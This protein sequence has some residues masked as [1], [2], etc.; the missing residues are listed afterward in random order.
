M[1]SYIAVGVNKLDK[2]WHG[3]FGISPYFIIYNRNG[4]LIE[5]RINPHG[6]GENHKHDHNNDQPLLIKDILHD[7]TTFIG[8]KM[9]EGS[10]LKLA[11]K[12]GVETIIS[13]LTEPQEVIEI[14]LKKNKMEK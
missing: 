7:C 13:K 9:G 11:E 1:S 2:I 4:E 12:F 14:V 10:K 5:K 8:K 6:A 3:H